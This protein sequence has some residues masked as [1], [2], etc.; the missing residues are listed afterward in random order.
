MLITVTYTAKWWIK[1]AHHYVW[2][3]S[4]KL[5]NTRTKKEINKTIKG[6][7]AGYWIDRKFMPL[8]ELKNKIELIPPKTYCPF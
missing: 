1:D 4:K 5:I 6:G 7:K 3:T 2:T 8:D